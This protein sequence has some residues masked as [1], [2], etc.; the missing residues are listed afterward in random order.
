MHQFSDESYIMN[1]LLEG[2]GCGGPKKPN[3]IN[4]PRPRPRPT[5]PMI[6]KQRL[7]E[8]F[9]EDSD[10]IADMNIGMMHQ[11][12]LWM[13]SIGEPFKNK[14]NALVY[15]AAYGKLDF[16]EYLLAAGAD[17]HTDNDYALRGASIEGHTEMVKVLLTA[18]ADVHAGDDYALQLASYSG[19]TEV[20]KVLLTAGADVHAGK[21]YA[22]RWA[23]N[24]GHTEVVKVLL[25][26]GADV[27]A[28][29]DYALRWASNYGHT[30]TV[31]VLKDH[32]A[33]GN[34]VEESVNEKFTEDSDPIHDMG[35]GMTPRKI[36]EKFILEFYTDVK[37]ISR[38]YFGD[39]QYVTLAFVLYYFF[40]YVYNLHGIHEA[41]KR[42][43]E[44]V[45]IDKDYLHHIQN[46]SKVADVLK[47]HFDIEVNPIFESENK[48][49]EKFT[50]DSDPIADLGI[51]INHFWLKQRNEV[52]SRSS[53]ENS[54]LYF[55]T[56]RY[57]KESLTI[58]ICL[59]EISKQIKNNENVDVQ[60]A[61]E[62]A[63]R[64]DRKFNGGKANINMVIRALKKFFYI[65]VKNSRIK[66]SK[67]NEYIMKNLNEKESKYDIKQ[68]SKIALI[69]LPKWVD[70]QEIIYLQ[71]EMDRLQ[72]KNTPDNEILEFLHDFIDTHIDNFFDI[73]IK[74]NTIERM[75]LEDHKDEIVSN[76][77]NLTISPNVNKS[78]DPK[79]QL[80]EEGDVEE[81]IRKSK[82]Q[83]DLPKVYS[84][85][86]QYD[87]KKEI[88][89]ALDTKDFDTLRK[90]QPYLKEGFLKFHVMEFLN[91]NKDE[92][93]LIKPLR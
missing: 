37:K 7:H 69:N 6:H 62:D 45:H 84:K 21:D 80:P 89:K 56:P 2:C 67:N 75:F 64:W 10:P 72:Q 78:L 11:I 35:I 8:K 44:A 31:K 42:A 14:D 12:K 50:E 9:T 92:E 49:N 54:Q 3:P 19:H 73:F 17:V 28:D 86:S 4:I 38:T 71:N 87:L 58:Y 43:C 76:I 15:S 47:K 5:K 82:V 26:A 23:S 13:E 55:K 68:I 90:I 79:L 77:I 34:K 61:F 91:E 52:G 57:M 70:S 22:L 39:E 16:V 53:A 81:I 93:Y 88:D 48:I 46:R 25:A 63:I 29:K 83:Q 74:Y 18:G 27:H 40:Q 41:F 24:Y 85:M 66:E 30:E 65:N 1:S 32:I 60:Q 51:G 59:A 20:V 36:A 33:K